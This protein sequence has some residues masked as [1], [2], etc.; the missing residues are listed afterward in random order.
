MK[1]SILFLLSL[2]L[3]SFTVKATAADKNRCNISLQ[4]QA[5]IKMEIITVSLV[6]VITWFRVQLTTNLTSGI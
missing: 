6:L 3:L 4:K 5:T 1:L 2:L